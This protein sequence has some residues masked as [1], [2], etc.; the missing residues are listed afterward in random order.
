MKTAITFALGAAISISMPAISSAHPHVF[1]EARSEIVFDKAGRMTAV[2]HSW[3]FDEA[4]TAFS[5]QG[6]DQNGD[7]E[8]T[9]EELQ[10]LAEINVESLK[11]Y[12]YFTYLYQ[13]DDELGFAE[14]SEYWLDFYGGR[15][16]LFFTLPLESP[17]ISDGSTF[18]LDV[19]D[20]TYFVAYEMTR[21]TPFAMVDA[22]KNCLLEFTPPPRLD[23]GT[24]AAL[25][26]IPSTQRDIP[27]EFQSVTETLSNTATVTCN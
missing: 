24:A 9:T 17:V 21:D 7:N 3:R 16:T 26:Q 11:E 15:L 14:P 27:D 19:Y 10:P 20:P 8:L 25:A 22:P 6:L 4:F 1:V 13:G 18:A 2:R 23:S 5:I 12:A